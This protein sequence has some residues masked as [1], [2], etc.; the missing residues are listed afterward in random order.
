MSDSLSPYELQQARLP[1]SSLAPKVCSNPCPLSRWCHPTTSSSV[2]PFS[3]C[4]QSFPSIR[5]FCNELALCIR[6]PSTGASASTSVLLMNIQGWFHLGLTGLTSL[7]QLL[8]AIPWPGIKTKPPS[9]KM[10]SLNRLTAREVSPETFLLTKRPWKWK[11]KLSLLVVSDFLRPHGLEPPRLLRPW[12][13]AGK[14]TGV[15]CHF[16]LQGIF[17][18]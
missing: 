4:P 15:G 13:F 16:L 2:V 17:P 9:V 11:W 3:S 10:W 8:S 18:T 5:V 7:G 12:N 14:S 1:C 6:W